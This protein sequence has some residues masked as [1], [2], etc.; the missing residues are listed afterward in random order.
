MTRL[1]LYAWIASWLSKHAIMATANCVGVV[2][3]SHGRLAVTGLY[4]LTARQ[5]MSFREELRTELPNTTSMTMHGYE[6]VLS[7]QT[8]STNDG[9]W[10]CHV[11]HLANGFF[12]E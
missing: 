4:G 10:A 12:I 9:P 6:L 11:V 5:R 3:A 2:E 1:E 7:N 8:D